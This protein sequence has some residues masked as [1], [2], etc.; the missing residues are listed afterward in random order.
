MRIPN[1]T[2]E[3]QKILNITWRKRCGQFPYIQKE[4]TDYIR[5]LIFPELFPLTGWSI[6]F[7]LVMWWS[8]YAF[9]WFTTI[10]LLSLPIFIL[11][12]EKSSSQRICNWVSLN[13]SSGTE[14]LPRAGQSYVLILT[15]LEQCENY[16][17]STRPWRF[18]GKQNTHGQI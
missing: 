15:S 2:Q 9:G 12:L 8:R 13:K 5:Y 14:V 6:L 4:L 11:D 18:I 3:Q 7:A 1:S 17:A 16:L 10:T